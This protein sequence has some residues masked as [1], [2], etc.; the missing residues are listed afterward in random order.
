MG[1]LTHYTPHGMGR[2][3]SETTQCHCRLRH[4][5]RRRALGVLARIEAN[6]CEAASREAA[7]SQAHKAIGD[8]LRANASPDDAQVSG[9]V[10]NVLHVLHGA[11]GLP[12]SEAVEALRPFLNTMRGRAS[13]ID[14]IADASADAVGA[15]VQRL[16]ATDIATNDLWEEAIEAS[17]SFANETA[18]RTRPSVEG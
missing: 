10:H 7:I 11:R 15:L 9:G 4:S 18:F 13:G 2:K 17:L 1:C 14:V 3:G 5:L 6:M 8:G 12:P 16:E